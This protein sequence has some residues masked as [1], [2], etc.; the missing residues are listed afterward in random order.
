M[1]LILL[2]QSQP[3]YLGVL[4]KIAV[5]AVLVPILT[6]L[7]FLGVFI[8]PVSYYIVLGIVWFLALVYRSY[9]F[10]RLFLGAAPPQ[11][12]PPIT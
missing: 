6:L 5:M 9:L 4:I 12:G 1:W 7:V 10:V 2:K 11:G 8:F 3:G